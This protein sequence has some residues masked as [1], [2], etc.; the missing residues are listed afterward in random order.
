MIAEFEVFSW[1]FCKNSLLLLSSCKNLKAKSKRP[2]FN[3]INKCSYNTFRGLIM[4]EIK[5]ND[6]DIILWKVCI[7]EG[8]RECK[9]HNLTRMTYT[10]SLILWRSR[11]KAIKKS[12]DLC[13]LMNLDKLQISS[14]LKK[15][16][17]SYSS[18]CKIKSVKQVDSIRILVAFK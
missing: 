8:F 6:S 11:Y 12:R 10:I 13:P 5:D 18:W 14:F 9:E 16:K 7:I 17:V 1:K 15:I 3:S 4:Q 2:R